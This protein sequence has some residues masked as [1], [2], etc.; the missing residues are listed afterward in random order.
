MSITRKHNRVKYPY[1]LNGH[2]LKHVDVVRYLGVQFSHDLHWDKITSHPRLIQ[3][4]VF[5][6]ATSIY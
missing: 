1:T 2:H 6:V 3:L 5:S 4:L